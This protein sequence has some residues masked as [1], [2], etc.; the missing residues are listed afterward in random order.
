[1]IGDFAKYDRN[2]SSLD[3]RHIAL[4]QDVASNIAVGLH[5]S[6]KSN[7]SSFYLEKEVIRLQEII[8]P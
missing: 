1:L 7:L 8:D 5:P 3:K 2:I 4:M 6:Y